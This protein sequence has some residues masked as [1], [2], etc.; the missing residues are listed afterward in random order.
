MALKHN[1][2]KDPLMFYGASAAIILGG[3]TVL[4]SL[5]SSGDDED[6]DDEEADDDD[7]AY[8][9]RIRQSLKQKEELNLDLNEDE[10]D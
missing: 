8:R 9:K 10:R 4:G 1:F 3:I 2:A 5:F 6:E 7:A